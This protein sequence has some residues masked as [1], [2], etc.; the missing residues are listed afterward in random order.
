MTLDTAEIRGRLRL[1]DD[2]APT[3]PLG[4]MSRDGGTLVARTAKD[5]GILSDRHI[6]VL[7]RGALGDGTTDD[8]AAI[9]T[10]ITYAAAN[11]LR[12]YFPAGTYKV[13]S[14]LTISTDKLHIFGDGR[15][16]TIIS[17]AGSGP[18]FN[19]TA[20]EG[21][22]FRDFKLV[23][24]NAS[25][26]STTHGIVFGYTGTVTGYQY[27]VHNVHIVG[28]NAST[29]TCGLRCTNIEHSIFEHVYIYGCGIGFFADN[30]THTGSAHG[31]NNR[32]MECR[33]QECTGD[34]WNINWQTA[35]VF[36]NC[37]AFKNGA[38]N[39]QFF[40]RGSCNCCKVVNLDVEQWAQADNALLYQTTIGLLAS[41]SKHDISFNAV[42][43]AQA[44]KGSTLTKSVIHPSTFSSNTSGML[45]D[46]ASNDN[47]V[48]YFGDQTTDQGARNYFTRGNLQTKSADYTMLST[49]DVVLMSGTFSATLTAA[50]RVVP[51]KIKT[52]KNIG[53]GTVTVV[54]TIDGATNYSLASQNKFVSV[55]S[56]GTSWYVV[57]AN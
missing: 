57:G 56:D 17:Y 54:G 27:A 25:G 42:N 31:I 37:Q 32:W 5:L 51:G 45:F 38:T 28:F 35:S 26:N 14:T 7:E 39:A 46:S 12:L 2:A 3:V 22:R 44:F 4:T 49:D 10:A 24:A 40:L 6:S 15:G 23:A 20:F 36:T 55:V 33:A 9:N 47:D 29:S 50:T 30:S 48:D 34:G 53:S 13:T 21:V 11:N 19:V 18:A 8:T 41:G 1:V 16:G 43:L 52:V